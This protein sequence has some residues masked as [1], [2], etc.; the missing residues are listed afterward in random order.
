MLFLSAS[1]MAHA[2]SLFWTV[3]ALVAIE[4]HRDRPLI[5]WALLG[6]ISLGM[7][8]LT[9]PF[10]AV[11]VGPIAGL[12]ALGLGARR[13]TIGGLAVIGGTAMIVASLYFAYNFV[14]TG[15]PLLAPH[16]MWADT[17]FGPGVDAF[18][19][20]PNVGI[21]LW[22]NVDPLPGHGLA[23]VALNA[24]K[25]FSLLNFE[26]FGWAAGSLVFACLALQPGGLRR[27]D[28]LMLGIIVS[29]IVGHSFYWAPG[30]PDFGARYWYLMLIPLAVLTVK[31][32]EVVT[33]RLAAKH[34]DRAVVAG[35]TAAWVA[36]AT[37]SAFITVMPWRSTVKY[38]R[39]RDIG[40]EF[41]T[42]AEQRGIHH[43]LVF[44]R[45]A[46]RSDYQA[47]FNFNT[48][49]FDSGDNVFVRDVGTE[50]AEPVIRVFPDRTVW[51]V[52]RDS[53][54]AKTIHVIA[55]PLPAGSLPPGPSVPTADSLQ[56]II[57]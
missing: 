3:L 26:L 54:A 10:D 38:H 20:G 12:W 37:V 27:R 51:V 29:V 11:L 46:R 42:V 55:G 14:L 31:G 36:L 4:R 48:V 19:F 40:A 15:H 45:S 5:R 39:Y 41:Q 13:L 52:G 53:E 24:N 9:R 33:E 6:G 8:F 18:G 28:G 50:H 56:A 21:P 49:P 7:V 23:D 34:A 30:G 32:M 16:Q 35:R 1:L 43:A 2:A 25:N 47:A 44:V 57:R 22:R 17:L